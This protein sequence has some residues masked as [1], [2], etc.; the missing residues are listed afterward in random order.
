VPRVRWTFAAFERLAAATGT[1]AP[2][3]IL[4]V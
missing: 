3:H 2:P 1:T 4:T